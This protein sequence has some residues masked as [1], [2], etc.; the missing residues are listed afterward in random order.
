MYIF[1]PFSPNT[2]PTS[3]LMPKTCTIIKTHT[4]LSD[5]F[6]STYQVL[7]EANVLK[8]PG[9]GGGGGGG[10][11]GSGSGN[12]LHGSNQTLHSQHEMTPARIGRSNPSV[13]VISGGSSA[14]SGPSTPVHP[15]VAAASASG[16]FWPN[17][18]CVF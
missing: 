18:H 3:A 16:I 17:F 2:Y 13:N 14:H 4:F 8:K 9:G 15:S 5:D 6:D 7:K 12:G 1:Q 11:S 10:S